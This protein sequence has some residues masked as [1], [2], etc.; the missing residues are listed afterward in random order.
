MTEDD[1]RRYEKLV[2]E[3]GFDVKTSRYDVDHFG[4][5]MI[6]VGRMDLPQ[7]RIVWDGKDRTLTVETAASNGWF[8]KWFGPEHA[9]G[10][11]L[12]SLSSHVS[13]EWLSQ[14]ERERLEGWATFYL[15]QVLSIAVGLW[16]EGRYA[17][18]VQMLSPHR[19]RLSPAQL[20]RLDL[21]KRRA[22]DG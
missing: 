20:K 17:E 10:A 15:Q 7:Q 21:A 14:M 6:V 12:A 11:A 4:N 22:A 18:Y 19:E 8:P 9:S 1:F 2:T 3:A 16:E 13:Q 5:W